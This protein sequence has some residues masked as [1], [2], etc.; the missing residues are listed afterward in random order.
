MPQRCPYLKDECIDKNAYRF[1]LFENRYMLIFQIE[2]DTVYVE[3][4]VDTRQDYG[5]LLN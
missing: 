5:W 3:Y 4:M 2:D 1:I